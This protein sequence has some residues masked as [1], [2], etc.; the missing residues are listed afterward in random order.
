MRRCA[1]WALLT[2]VLLVPAAR[3]AAGQAGPAPWAGEAPEA[4]VYL[5]TMGVGA[6]VWE[7]F[8]HNMIW[9]RDPETGTDLA[10]DWGVFSFQQENF[11]LR[12][13]QGRM[14]Y[15]MR[16]SPADSEIRRY[17]RAGRSVWV[18]ELALT[19]AQRDSLRDF[20][21]W[22]ALEEN[23]Y[24]RYDY[25]WDNCSTR[26]RDALDRVLGGAIRRALD[27][28]PAGGTFR[29][30]TRRLT[31]NDVGIYTGLLVGLGPMV[32]RPVT[33]WDEAFLPLAFREDV[34]RVRVAAPD[35]SSIPLVIR[36]AT[37]FASDAYPVPDTPP[38]WTRWYLVVGLL[39]GV[40]LAT[41]GGGARLGRMAWSAAAVGWSLVTGLA[42]AVLAAI[43]AFTDHAVAYWNVNL[44]Q[45]T[46]FALALAL[47]LPAFLRGAAWAARP[48]RTL[49][50]L[51]AGAS[52]LG[53][54]VAPVLQQVNGEL[55][56]FLV[57]A[58]VGLAMGVWR[59]ARTLAVLAG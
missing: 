48:A 14:R 4:G 32:D 24:Y 33:A 51:V 27:S 58:N 6:A 1:R 45:L 35:G 29:F 25:Y 30:H 36:E 52:L 21:A 57:P 17:V 13:V 28:V 9:I 12:F 49:A 19:P 37:L 11:L 43:W 42:G 53:M 46:L 59:R 50:A 55:L 8:G 26:V 5:L 34:R 41:A 16:G 56:A 22:N 40:G 39:V 44:L 10:Y 23:K 54:A 31:T 20:L 7:R 38:R 18:Q 2:A 3:P 15:W 47:I